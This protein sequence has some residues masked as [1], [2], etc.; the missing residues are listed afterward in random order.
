MS[1]P[2]A[3]GHTLKRS[4]GGVEEHADEADDSQAVSVISS[5]RREALRRLAWRLDTPA[6]L[7]A[8]FAVA[9]LVRVLLAPYFGFHGDLRLFGMWAQRLAAVGPHKFY[10]PGQFADYPPGYL[11][12]L[13]ITG[14]LSAA[15]SYLLLKLPAL[16]ADLG[17]AWIAGTLAARIAPASLKERWPVRTLVAASV[18]FNPAVIALSAVWGQVD[19]VPAMLVLWSLLLLF[20]GRQSL[21]RELEAFVLFAVAIA[22]KPQSGFVVPLMLY[23]LYR[24]YLHRRTRPELVDGALSIAVIGAVSLGLWAVSG[25]AFGLRPDGLLRFYRQSASVY[26]VTSA[27]AFNLWGA[28]AF[29]RNDSTG[30]HVLSVAGI[31]ALRL[32]MLAFL[33]GVV[34][35]LWRSHRAIERGSDEARV[36][37]VGAATTSLLAYTLLTRMHERYMF[38]SLAVLTPL[39]FVP[40][41]RLAL[42]GLSAL[43]LLNLWW[44]YAYFNSQWRVE[45]L[46]LQPFFDWLYGGF[47]T[48]T[49]QKRVWSLAV[50]AIA[51][52][53]TWR[54][55][56]WVGELEP[57]PARGSPEPE[58]TGPE[59]AALP[60]GPELVAQ[61]HKL[62]PGGPAHAISAEQSQAAATVAVETELVAQSH[63]LERADGDGRSGEAQSQTQGPA[64]PEHDL[65][66]QSHK[67][68]DE[69]PRAATRVARWV[70]VALVVLTCLF[71]LFVLRDETSPAPTLNDSAFHL[72]MVDW[73]AGQIKEG[74]VPL[75][76]WFPYLSLGSALFHHYQSLPHTLTAYAARAT[77]AG[78]QTA[79]LWLMYLLLATWPIS[80]YLGA[81]WLDWDRWTAGASAAVSP[82]I[83]SASG[84]GYEHGSYT[85]RGYGVYTQLW[86]MWLLPLAWGLTWR[87]VAHGKRYAAAALALALTMA[88]HFITGYLAMLTIGVWVIV[89][90]AGF[91]RRV[92]R[93]A[94]VAGG[95]VLVAAWVLVP[96]I[97]DTKWTTRSEYYVG[98]IFND[99]YGARKVLGWLVRGQLFDSGRFP[100]VSL[101]FAAGLVTCIARARRD[102][103]ARALLGVFTLSLLLFFGR[104]T[105]GRALDVLPGFGDVQIHRFVMGVHLAGILLAGVALGRLLRI[106]YRLV[107]EHAPERYAAAGAAAV[108]LGLAVGVLA[109]GWTERAGYDRH[110]AVLIRAQQAYDRASAKDLDALVNIV[111]ARGGGRVYAGLRAN[112]GRDYKVG[113]VPVYAWLAQ[114]D[115]DAIGFT[116]RTIASLSTDVEA[117]FDETNPAQYEMFDVRYLLLPAGHPPPVPATLIASRGENRLYE[118][119]TT[120]YV[121]VVDRASP[122]SA[123][124]TDIEQTTRSFRNSDL[125]S[126][127]VYPGVGFAGAAGPPALDT[128][129][130]PPGRVLSQSATIQDGVFGAAVEANRRAVVL[131]KATYD[132]RWTATV[133]GVRAKPVMMAPSL[134]G[135]EVPPGRHSVRFRYAPYG[136]YPMLLTIGVL[137]LLGLVLVDRRGL[138]PLRSRYWTGRTSPER[139]TWS[140]R[141]GD[142]S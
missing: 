53:V 74:R 35:V 119:R 63:K 22:M 87:A 24:R 49:W 47:A 129:P 128:G 26:P 60:A 116:F 102:V 12:V 108:A 14:K 141:A 5:S 126:R 57:R 25:L 124:R 75:D 91:L 112:W 36:L 33:A 96:L 132:P 120:G 73:A 130:G 107:A 111:K 105:L 118:V 18:L 76:G 140:E 133:D 55:V 39:V 6:G 80:V 3:L 98:T 66:A 72:E 15:P 59:G 13:W 122:I 71:G 31:S 83:V 20:T 101:L 92:G 110:G 84:Y 113:Y 114:R 90:G 58:G 131:L 85:W 23:S 125:A 100:I 32:G 61:S 21:R 97:G 117:A 78:D 54:G 42:A 34:Y 27:N 139:A 115:V 8:M 88:C 1:T 9:F 70:P 45:D 109:P 19:S 62:E 46:R 50:V 77:G 94:L 142:G 79:F 43:F 44:P 30:D 69:P 82:L 4:G 86:A 64:P 67:L 10:V 103:R 51:L 138:R 56:R 135:V 99:S 40:R 106:A 89:L 127:A 38:L 93:A 65:V 48:D 28:V 136:H 68:Q 41:L 11:Y 52:A 95:A 134:V 7:V 137:A 17:L 104:P 2:A 29:W 37:M 121:Q 123:N 16:V 81:R